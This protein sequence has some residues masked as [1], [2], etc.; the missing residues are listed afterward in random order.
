[1]DDVEDIA[2]V[3]EPSKDDEVLEA[4]VEDDEAGRNT[5]SAVVVEEVVGPTVR[6]DERE[7]EEK[8]MTGLG[9]RGFMSLVEDRQNKQKLSIKEI[10]EFKVPESESSEG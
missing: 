1:M 2:E 3:L 8:K 9:G 10:A 5:K 6:T 4:G 7:E